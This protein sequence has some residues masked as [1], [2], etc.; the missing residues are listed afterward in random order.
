MDDGNSNRPNDH[1]PCEGPAYRSWGMRDRHSSRPPAARAASGRL[2]SRGDHSSPHSSSCVRRLPGEPPQ[3]PAGPAENGLE[4]HHLAQAPAHRPLRHVG[5]VELALLARRRLDRHAGRRRRSEARSSH[6]V[7]VVRHGG[8]AALEASPS[9]RT[10]SKMLVAVGD[11][12][13]L[14]LPLAT[15]HRA[16]RSRLSLS[17]SRRRRVRLRPSPSSSTEPIFGGDRGMD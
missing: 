2:R 6:G 14:L 5:E 12:F 16:E 8:V 9:A 11:S 7:E 10:M 4:A 15:A 3:P 1:A 17:S 13:V